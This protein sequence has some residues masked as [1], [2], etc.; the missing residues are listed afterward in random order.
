MLASLVSAVLA[1]VGA[2]VIETNPSHSRTWELIV[3]DF[4]IISLFGMGGFLIAAVLGV[5]GAALALK[6][7]AKPKV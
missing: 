1:F 2:G 3:L 6:W 5:T 4:S 7:K